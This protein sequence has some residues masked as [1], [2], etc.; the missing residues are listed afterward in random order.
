MLLNFGLYVLTV[1]VGVLGEVDVVVVGVVG[2]LAATDGGGPGTT[3][4]PL[5]VDSFVHS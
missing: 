1:E 4:P 5:S 3:P 2:V